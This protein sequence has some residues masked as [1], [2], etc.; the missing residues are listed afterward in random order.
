MFKGNLVGFLFSGNFYTGYFRVMDVMMAKTWRGKTGR[1]A[2]L[3]F[4]TRAFDPYLFVRIVGSLMLFYAR[5]MLRT[6]GALRIKTNL[7]TNG[8]MMDESRVFY[9]LRK[10]GFC[11]YARLNGTFRHVRGYLFCLQIRT[12]KGVFLQRAR[13]RSRSLVHREDKRVGV[14]SLRKNTILNVISNGSLGRYHAIHG[15][16][17]GQSS[18]IREK[19]M[20]GRSMAKCYAVNQFSSNGATMKA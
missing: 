2:A 3:C 14:L 9:Y 10:R 6:I 4:L 16:F 13:F 7:Y 11:S 1:S 19:Y 15:V 5:A 18:L 8:S 12:L 17:S 20:N